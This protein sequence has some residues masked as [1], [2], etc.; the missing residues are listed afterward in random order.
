MSTDPNAPPAPDTR[1]KAIDP[2][3][4]MSVDV[5]APKGGSYEYRGQT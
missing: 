4:G 2:I 3:C 5:A 1:A